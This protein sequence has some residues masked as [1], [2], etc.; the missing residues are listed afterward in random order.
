MLTTIDDRALQSLTR[1]PAATPAAER[2]FE[3]QSLEARIEM[4]T[5][6][7]AAHA[8]DVDQTGR[9]PQE[10]IACLRDHRLLG[11]MI[12]VEFGGEGARVA[13]VMEVCY[14]L[15]QVCA[16]SAMIFA[17]HQ[18][19]VACLVRHG[20]GVTWHE[21]MMRRICSE[22][23]LVASSTT[24]G[25]GGGNIRSSDAPIEYHGDQITL[26]R[27][28]S[29]I[30]Y[31]AQAD[32][33][34]TTARRLNE[35]SA[36][37]Q[38]L[39]VFARDD[40][41]LEPTSSW[42]TL[43]MRGTCS[44]GFTLRASGKVEQILPVRY[45]DIHTQTMV[46]CAHLMWGAAWAGI[47]AGAVAS[48]QLFVRNAARRS[49]GQL[50]PAAAHFTKAIALLNT[51]RGVLN[52]ALRRYEQAVDSEKLLRS[53]EFQTAMNLTKVEASELAV[54]TVMS[55]LR[56]CGLAG[57]RNDTPFSIGRRLRDVLSSL[58]MI[59]NERILAGVTATSLVSG[60]PASLRD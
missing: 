54:E 4:A 55:A 35:A 40:Y 26:E 38:V 30:S 53:L 59:N 18:V 19:N 47:A 15:G 16:T 10:A 7:A 41:T 27:Q 29:V 45:E 14:G 43:G 23:L 39:V 44:V 21:Q 31:G 28:A 58:I 6:T 2:A 5:A 9:F 37:D 48:T 56:V 20:R 49:G 34:V 13:D 50:P 3:R 52:S 1:H 51:L 32:A 8:A 57:Y 60:L 12:P 24:E 33:I 25:Q 36:S 46:P 11:T 42:D 17:M 22:Q